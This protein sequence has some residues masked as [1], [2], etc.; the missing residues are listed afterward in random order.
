MS[1]STAPGSLPPE[2]TCAYCGKPAACFGSYEGSEDAF[3]CDT[4]CGHGNE[5]GACRQIVEAP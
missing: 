1:G 4:C 2:P 3:A 5:D